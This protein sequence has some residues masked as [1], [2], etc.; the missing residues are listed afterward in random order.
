MVL[1]TTPL[2]ASFI[3]AS[4]LAPADCVH[5]CLELDSSKFSWA[6]WWDMVAL[7]KNWIAHIYVMH[8]HSEW[9][10]HHSPSETKL[11]TGMLLTEFCA[12]SSIIYQICACSWAITYLFVLIKHNPE[13]GVAPRGQDLIEPE[14][15]GRKL[16]KIHS[17]RKFPM[18]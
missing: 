11:W 17:R 4:L 2:Q 6:C 7:V 15:V 3:Q 5:M 16:C 1:Q 14:W 8:G 10:P 18:C 13:V 9:K 12:C